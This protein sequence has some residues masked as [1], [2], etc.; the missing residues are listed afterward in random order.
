MGNSRYCGARL[1]IN[2]WLPPPRLRV[3]LFAIVPSRFMSGMS[4]IPQAI[5]VDP[6]RLTLQTPILSYHLEVFVWTL[7]NPPVGQ[8]KKFIEISNP[9]I[10]T[11]HLRNFNQSYS[12]V[13]ISP[14]S[15]SIQSLR[16]CNINN[17][18]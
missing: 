11:E 9:L 16:L 12:S 17:I 18:L 15:V 3:I 2:L 5:E 1:G 4:V 7:G 13:I 8:D 6:F 10:S 14:I